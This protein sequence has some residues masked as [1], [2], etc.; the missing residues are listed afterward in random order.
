[1]TKE[2]PLIAYSVMSLQSRVSGSLYED[3]Q[4]VS[5]ED[6]VGLCLTVD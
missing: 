2:N 5:A 4:I 6:V 3:L 1:M